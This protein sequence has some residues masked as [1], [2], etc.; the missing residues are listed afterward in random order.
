VQILRKL[1]GGA[2]A[3][4]FATIVTDLASA[5]C[6]WFNC[7]SDVTY[8]PTDALVKVAT[9]RGLKPEQVCN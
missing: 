6:T 3:I 4:P 8:V 9:K 2:K 7:G 1:G 5:H